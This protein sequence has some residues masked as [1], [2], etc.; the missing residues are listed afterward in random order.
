MSEIFHDCI[1]DK[2]FDRVRVT[3]MTRGGSLIEWRIADR[4]LAEKKPPEPFHFYV[5]YG[6]PGTDTWCPLNPDDPVINDCMFVDIEQ[7]MF[8]KLVDH[9]YRVRLVLPGR[10]CEEHISSPRQANMGMD[11]GNFLNAREIIRKEHLYLRKA[12]GGPGVKG[13]LLKRKQFG[14]LCGQCLDHDTREVTDSSCPV[15]F[16]TR[17]LGGYYAGI[18]YWTSFKGNWQRRKETDEKVQV[19]ENIHKQGR[20]VLF[21]ANYDFGGGRGGAVGG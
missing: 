3:H 14:Q 10:N 8:G 2:V 20:V 9:Y 12:K 4:F 11:R 16:G 18:E 15:C 19:V 21:A 6:R 13:V 1:P 5:D 7:R 17:F